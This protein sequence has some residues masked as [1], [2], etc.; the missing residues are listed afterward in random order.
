MVENTLDARPKNDE[1]SKPAERKAP[2]EHRPAFQLSRQRCVCVC[3]LNQGV[4]VSVSCSRCDP[5]CAVVDTSQAGRNPCVG[6][7]YST[8]S[9][10]GEAFSPGP[11]KPSDPC[12]SG[13]LL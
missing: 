11:Y 1:M 2:G 13:S 10:C 8:P 9:D 7:S 6:N 3:I 4:T 12:H 5:C